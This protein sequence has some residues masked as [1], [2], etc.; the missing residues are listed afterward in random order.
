MRNM[1]GFI[2]DANDGAYVAGK[3]IQ[4]IEVV[5]ATSVKVHFSGDDNTSGNAVLTVTSGKSDDIAKEI[6]RIACTASGVVTVADSLNSVFA[7]SD[8]SAVASYSVN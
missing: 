2:V 5:S 6:A 8:I 7:H 3:N 1:L 4:H